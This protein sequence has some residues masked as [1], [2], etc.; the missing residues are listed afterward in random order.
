MRNTNTNTL[1]AFPFAANIC[2]IV[3]LVVHYLTYLIPTTVI[4]SDQAFIDLP[5][6][7]KWAMGITMPNMGLFMG[8]KVLTVLE[9]NGL[10]L[11]W[12]NVSQSVYETTKLSMMDVFLMFII[13]I[14]LYLVI[15][16]YLEG[17]MPG[18]FGVARKYYF[19]F[20]VCASL[21]WH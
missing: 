7:A 11:Q 19:P 16:W 2:L 9:A 20:Q 13:G 1:F 21:L 14:V 5:R 3:V 15:M 17:I 12:D 18:K 4:G 10:G 8:C 6:G